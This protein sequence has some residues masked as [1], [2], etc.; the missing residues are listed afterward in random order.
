MPELHGLAPIFQA[1]RSFGNKI[2]LLTDGRLS[3]A[4][5]SILSAIHLSPEA[6]ANGP[7]SF[8]QD[9]DMITI[10]SNQGL[11]SV[12]ADFTGRKPATAPTFELDLDENYSRCLGKMF[13][14]QNLE[15]TH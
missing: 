7:I 15:E 13:H 3:G 2:A 1:I 12:Q 4:S 14:L 8:I 11:I 5:G 6:A 9:G 10:D